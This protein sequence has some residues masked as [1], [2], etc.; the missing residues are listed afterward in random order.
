MDRFDES[1]TQ[2]KALLTAP[3]ERRPSA[4]GALAAGMVAAMAAVLLAG[5]VILGPG[6]TFDEPTAVAEAA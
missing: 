6:A 1:L 2:A 3:V 5:V 4:L